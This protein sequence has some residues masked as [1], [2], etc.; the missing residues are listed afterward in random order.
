M[1]GVF[2]DGSRVS[3]TKARGLGPSLGGWGW[4]LAEGSSSGYVVCNG[5]PS[6]LNSRLQLVG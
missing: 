4:T 6:S 3:S 1:L 2:R 5:A